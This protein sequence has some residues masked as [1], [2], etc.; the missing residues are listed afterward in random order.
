M[1]KYRVP[2]FVCQTKKKF[3]SEDGDF[4]TDHNKTYQQRKKHRSLAQTAR[5]HL[6]VNH[7]HMEY[8]PS[9]KFSGQ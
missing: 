9:K 6:L 5:M 2:Y 4:F 7:L 3:S 1:E 8:E